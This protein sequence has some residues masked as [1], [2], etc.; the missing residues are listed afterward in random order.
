MIPLISTAPAV[1][2]VTKPQVNPRRWYA[3]AVI[4]LPVLQISLNTYMIQVA[5]PLIQTSLHASFSEAQLIATGFSLGLAVALIVSGKLGDLYGRKRMILIGV[6]GFTITSAVGGLISDPGLLIAIRIVQGLTAALIQPQVLSTMQVSFPPKEKALAFGLYGALIGIGF[7][8]G[9]FLGGVI[10]HWNV[11]DLG[12]R[13]IFFIHV[14]FGVLIL[15][16]LR[17]VPE[18]HGGQ[19]QKMD[20]TGTSLLAVGLFLFVYPLS[21]GQKRG[22]PIW[23]LGCLLAATLILIAFTAVQI[24]KRNRGTF[25]LIDLNIFKHRTFRVGL[26]TAAMIYLGMFSFFFI[27]TFYLQFGLRYD[28]QS[29]SLVFLPL[30][31]G[32]FIASLFSSRLVG[33]WGTKVLKLGAIAMGS[34]SLLLIGSLRIDPVHLLHTRNIGILT[35]Y[36]FGLGMAA[37]PLV[38]VVLGAVPARDAGT[39]S[40]LFNTWMYLANSIGVALIGL[41]F[42]VVLGDSSGGAELPDYV[43]AFTSALAVTGGLGFLA[44][45]CL[46]FLPD[47]P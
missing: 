12:W 44:Y 18:T 29:T 25:P 45:I 2:S 20:W 32:F 46:C 23:T 5:L 15:S 41:L 47:R 19:V 35:I 7:A 39:G 28:V 33:R 6:C 38:N 8:F 43:R 1:E 36:G 16:L 31:A 26:V 3:L 24:R 9:L 30:G 11:Y 4:L 13:A 42:S 10:V 27:L 22:W 14:P 37:T 21:E 17:F 34:C 40:G